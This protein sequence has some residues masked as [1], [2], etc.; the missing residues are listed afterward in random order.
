MIARTLERISRCLHRGV[1]AP[2]RW[3]SY[4]VE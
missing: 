2:H 3:E 4:W 1:E